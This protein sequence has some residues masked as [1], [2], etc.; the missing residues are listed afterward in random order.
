MAIGRS[1]D[2]V[3]DAIGPLLATFSIQ[4]VAAVALFGIS[5]VAPAAAPDIGVDATLIGV[6]SA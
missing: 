3:G 2:T 1:D 4:T 5:V 6:F